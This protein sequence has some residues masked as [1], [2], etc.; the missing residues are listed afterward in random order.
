MLRSKTISPLFH[1]PRT[2][3]QKEEN[4]NK[5]SSI[6]TDG[7]ICSP[8]LQGFAYQSKLNEGVIV[9]GSWVLWYPLLHKGVGEEF[10]FSEIDGNGGV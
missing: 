9:N 2:K 8:K 5:Y 6:C 4:L 1:D 3:Q 10:D 7:K